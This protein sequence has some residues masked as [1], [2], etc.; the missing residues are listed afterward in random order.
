MSTAAGGRARRT[1]SPRAG[2][3]WGEGSERPTWSTPSTCGS[4]APHPDAARPSPCPSPARERGPALR[5]VAASPL[6]MR[7]SDRPHGSG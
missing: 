4:A 1:P 2:E 3:G 5:P 7:G 6:P